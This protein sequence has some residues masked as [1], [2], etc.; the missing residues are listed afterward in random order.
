MRGR[1]TAVIHALGLGLAA[2]GPRGGSAAPDLRTG[3][4]LR[5]T[6]APHATGSGATDARA[7]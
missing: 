6:P 2:A 7:R 1:V 3:A 4:P 5:P